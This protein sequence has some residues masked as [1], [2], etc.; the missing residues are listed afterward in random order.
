MHWVSDTSCE[1]GQRYSLDCHLLWNNWLWSSETARLC[2]LFLVALMLQ[3]QHS[4]RA[5]NT[6]CL[7]SKL[8]SLCSD[9]SLISRTQSI[10]LHSYSLTDC[11]CHIQELMQHHET[12]CQVPQTEPALFHCFACRETS[13]DRIIHWSN[14]VQWCGCFVISRI[15]DGDNVRC[16]LSFWCLK[17]FLAFANSNTDYSSVQGAQTSGWGSGM[18]ACKACAICPRRAA[19]C[20][21]EATV[22]VF[23]ACDATESEGMRTTVY[24][25]LLSWKLALFCL[26]A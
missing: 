2:S 26:H 24:N 6:W 8:K 4:E 13:F 10:D 20:L 14:R 23:P 21:S 3:A 7:T 22:T 15:P 5:L 19:K 1:L 9:G 25:S 18:M 16:H 12:E 17:L 11:Y